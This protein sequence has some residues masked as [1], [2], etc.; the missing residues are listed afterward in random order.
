VSLFNGKDK[1]GGTK[2]EAAFLEAEEVDTGS[3]KASIVSLEKLKRVQRAQEQHPRNLKVTLAIA[4]SEHHHIFK[5]QFPSSSPSGEAG[6]AQPHN[7]SW[8]RKRKRQGVRNQNRGLLGLQRNCR[9][10]EEVSFN[11]S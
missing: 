10:L 1:S 2:P 3:T 4:S 8:A 7:Q 6:E 5:R 9:A 11:V